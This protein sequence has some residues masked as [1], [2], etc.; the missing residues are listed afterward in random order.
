MTSRAIALQRGRTAFTLLEMMI[1]L[2]GLAAIG[3]LVFPV[4][5]D[6]LDRSARD[7][8]IQKLRTALIECRVIAQRSGRSIALTLKPGAL[9][10]RPWPAAGDLEEAPVLI[11]RFASDS[12]A[13][14]EDSNPQLVAVALSDGTFAANGPFQLDLGGG[15]LRHLHLDA[16]T[17]SVIEAAP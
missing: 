5:S 14:P 10:A 6:L 8:D 7:A 13:A 2:A 1:V 15:D 16:L 9:E 11:V 4:V 17:G 12:D 3:G